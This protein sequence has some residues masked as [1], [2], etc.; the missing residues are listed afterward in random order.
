MGQ[1]IV[2]L[3]E[4]LNIPRAYIVAFSMGAIV[5]GHLLTTS[6]DRFITANFVGH[7]AVR[8]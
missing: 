1:D 8:T 6:P 7:H 2:R 5:A 4:Y 3:L